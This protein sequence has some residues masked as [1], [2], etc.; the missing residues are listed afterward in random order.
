[1]LSKLTDIQKTKLKELQA[2]GFEVSQ[3]TLTLMKLSYDDDAPS[4]EQV[5]LYPA[6]YVQY[7]MP[8]IHT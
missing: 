7:E 1:V 5:T 8:N 2:D 6:G 4:V 3:V